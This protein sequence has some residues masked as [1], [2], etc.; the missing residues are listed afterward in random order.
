MWKINVY[1]YICKIKHQDIY[2]STEYFFCS[3]NK[4]ERLQKKST[5]LEQ[6]F[7][8]FALSL[9][10]FICN[11][12]VSEDSKKKKL[13]LEKKIEIQVSVIPQFKK[14]IVISWNASKKNFE[15]KK[16]FRQLYLHTFQNIAHIFGL[17][18]Q[19]YQFCR[20][21]IAGKWTNRSLGKTSEFFSIEI[22]VW[23]FLLLYNF[24]QI[25]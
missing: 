9:L 12:Y 17:K 16:Q 8:F 25:W 13:F 1:M 21:K 22:Y 6:T 20:E 11:I 18:I 19:N 10:H 3:S 14:K 23:L 7:I 24:L 15:Q 4:M 2:F 5:N